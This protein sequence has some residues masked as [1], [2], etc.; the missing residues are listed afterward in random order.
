MADTKKLNLEITVDKKA[1]TL[2]KESTKT[3]IAEIKALNT[4]LT[5]QIKSDALVK[6]QVEKTAQAQIKADAQKTAIE[7][8]ANKQKEVFDYKQVADQKS[9]AEKQLLAELNSYSKKQTQAE[10]DAL[11][12]RVAN[13]R[14]ASEQIS[15]QLKKDAQVIRQTEQRRLESVFRPIEKQ[16]TNT[17]G[18]QTQN[19]PFSPNSLA[20]L[21]QQQAY[22]QQFLSTLS[23]GNP[24]IETTKAKLVGLKTE[25]DKFAISTRSGA[26]SLDFFKNALVGGGVIGGLYMAK[27]AITDFIQEA[28][29]LQA[30]TLGLESVSKF[31][32][33]NPQVAVDSVKNLEL[34]KNGLLTVGDASL[35]LKNLLASNF[36]LEQSIELIKRFGDAAAFGRQAGLEFGYAITSATE[37]IKNGNS[38]LVD[39]AGITKNLSV[40]L[41]EAGLSAT[42][43]NKATSDLNVRMALYNGLLKETQ[44]FLGDANKLTQTF[45]GEQAKLDAQTTT[46]KQSLGEDFQKILINYLKGVNEAGVSTK[47]LAD[48]I[49]GLTT[50]SI[51]L[52]KILGDTTWTYFPN[53]IHNI[54]KEMG[55]LGYVFETMLNP[56]GSVWTL[57]Q[58]IYNLGQKPQEGISKILPPT[59]ADVM[60][61]NYTMDYKAPIDTKIAK[62]GEVIKKNGRGSKGSG[63]AKTVAE[64]TNEIIRLNKS[65]ADLQKEQLSLGE[66]A[67]GTSIFAIYLQQITEIQDKLK[68]LNS[69][70]KD[71]TGLEF[72]TLPSYN[73]NTPIAGQELSFAEQVNLYSKEKVD[74]MAEFEKLKSVSSSVLSDTENIMNIL[75]VGTNT[76]VSQLLN[77]FQSAISLVGSIVNILSALSGGGGGGIFGSLL[78]GLLSFIPGGGAISAVAGAIGGRNIG[79]LAMGGGGSRNINVNFGDMKFRLKGEDIYGSVDAYTTNLNNARY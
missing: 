66:S 38:I 7:L 21:K 53:A 41:T 17:G 22:Y 44:G 20:G 19:Q 56:L 5:A 68:Y 61:G 77:G 23:A 30:A 63:T 27:N 6:I 73:N 2:L 3:T 76:F 9:K 70:F 18:F 72:G 58:D 31:K 47:L 15:N 13:W 8:K 48:I 62:T 64:I 37:G 32:G 52:L 43:V 55:L 69:P 16:P 34:V 78:G 74:P 12:E 75:G 36:T 35:A 65:L 26:S 79:N 10:R 60:G 33:V 67:K 29:K 71:S 59:D 45:A 28:N 40:I 4:S 14:K 49:V 39:N 46:L 11:A 24:M 51:G 1:L 42:D 57:L 54:A 50:S 25:I